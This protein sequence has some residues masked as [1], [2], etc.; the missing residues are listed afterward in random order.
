[1]GPETPRNEAQEGRARSTLVRLSN[2]TDG[3]ARRAFPC[4]REHLLKTENKAEEPHIVMYMGEELEQAVEVFNNVKIEEIT[5]QQIASF[6]QI[7]QGLDFG[8]AVDPVSLGR[9]HFD[10]KK[11]TLYIFR[12]AYGIGVGNR[13]LFDRLAPRGAQNANDSR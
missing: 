11:R 9:M 7:R 3:M 10:R 4:R 5:D 2:S 13:A 6:D 12:E 8:Y 1:M